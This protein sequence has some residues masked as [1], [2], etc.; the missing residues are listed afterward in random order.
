MAYFERNS[1]ATIL[2]APLVRLCFGARLSFQT[3]LTYVTSTRPILGLKF[4][5]TINYQLSTILK[6]EAI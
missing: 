5:S 4:L 2:V 6:P 1:G 3:M